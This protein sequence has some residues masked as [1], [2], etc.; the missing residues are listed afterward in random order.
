MLGTDAGQKEIGMARQTSCIS[1]RL[2]ENI[3]DL[4]I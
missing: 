4:L 3:S 2:A 1:D